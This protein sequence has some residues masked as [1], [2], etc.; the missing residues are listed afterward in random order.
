M[1]PSILN[2]IKSLCIISVYYQR[3][4]RMSDEENSNF[5]CKRI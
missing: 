4:R 2:P 1:K 5:I 3:T